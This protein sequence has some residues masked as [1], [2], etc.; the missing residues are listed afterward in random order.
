MF[1]DSEAIQQMM[2]LLSTSAR[3]AK[4]E[5]LDF[6]MEKYDKKFKE[7]MNESPVQ[8]M[9]TLVYDWYQKE[10]A[11]ALFQAQ[12]DARVHQG[13]SPASAEEKAFYE[14]S[15]GV[16]I[17]DLPAIQQV[18]MD[19]AI[20]KQADF[21][22]GYSSGN[23]ALDEGNTVRMDAIFNGWLVSN[24]LHNQDGVIYKTDSNGVIL[25]DKNN[26]QQIADADDFVRCFEDPQVA[27]FLAYV[28]KIDK[29][30]EVS[31]V[32]QPYPAEQVSP[33]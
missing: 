27:G 13:G 12:I 2:T 15:F 29:G 28:E 16:K 25:L 10:K 24:H 19:Y 26:R 9:K 33:T 31:L 6:C 8:N 20:S 23:Q 7:K 32:R 30:L 21:L 3:Q 4:V 1:P 22:R 18:Q 14:Q 5:L 17:D 11:S